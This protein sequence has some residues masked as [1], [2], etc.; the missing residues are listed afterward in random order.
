MINARAIDKIARHVDDAVNKGARVVAGGKRLTTLGPNYY[1]PTVLADATSD[2]QLSCEET[3]GPVVPL[4]RFDDEEQ[5]IR[6][7]NDT[8]F[9]LAS[10][11]Y[12]N[13]V[14]RIDRVARQLEAGI[15]GINEGALASEAAPFGGVKESGYG[16]EGS[17]YGLDDYLS[18]KY[19]CQGG[20]E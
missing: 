12:S 3:F 20:L 7:A 1:A 16:R 5:A 8:P 9:G 14:R 18:I 4:F 13:D 15:V 17:K 2:M 11:F 6:A 10:Y 19:L